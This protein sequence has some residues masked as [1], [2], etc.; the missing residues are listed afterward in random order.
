MRRHPEV[1]ARIVAGA[2]LSEVSDWVRAHHERPDGSGY[3]QGLGGDTIPDGAALLAI[4]DAW[5][6]MTSSR[7]Y[8]APKDVDGAW[9]EC[10]AL[11]GAQFTLG[12]VAALSV[13]YQQGALGGQAAEAQ[14]EPS[15]RR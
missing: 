5:D 11:V 12:A 13:L 7:S 15:M 3:P 9:S 2:Q 14:P 10:R 6:V 1:G 8:S 4:A